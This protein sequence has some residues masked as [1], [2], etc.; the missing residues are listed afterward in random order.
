MPTPAEDVH[1]TASNAESAI[2]QRGQTPQG[3]S[4]RL[5]PKNTGG[6]AKGHAPQLEAWKKSRK[7]KGRRSG[8]EAGVLVLPWTRPRSLGASLHE[9]MCPAWRSSVSVPAQ[10]QPARADRA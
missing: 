7:D 6:G 5:R 10:E 3:R 9:V 8:R 1:W 2:P 4:N